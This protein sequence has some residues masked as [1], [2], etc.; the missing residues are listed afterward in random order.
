MGYPDGLI[1]NVAESDLDVLPPGDP[2]DPNAPEPDG[3]F[4]RDENSTL[5]WILS[6]KRYLV[7]GAVLPTWKLWWSLSHGATTSMLSTYPDGGTLG[8][9]DGTLVRGSTPAVYLVSG[10]TRRHIANAGVFRASGFQWSAVRNVDDSTLAYDA[11][12]PDITS[13]EYPQEGL[14]V[15]SSDDAANSVW[16]VHDGVR[17]YVSRSVYLTIANWS[18]LVRYPAVKVAGV[19]A[20]G[21]VTYREGSLLGSPSGSVYLVGSGSLH[22]IRSASEFDAMGLSWSSVR[23]VPWFDVGLEPG[24]AALD[25]N[26]AYPDGA[27]TATS[28]GALYQVMDGRRHLVTGGI[29]DA[30]AASYGFS[31]GEVLRMNAATAALP[32]GTPLGFREGEL[33]KGS[34]STVYL[35]SDGTR[36]GFTSAGIFTGLGYSFSNVRTVPDSYLSLDPLGAYI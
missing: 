13:V 14:L 16:L 28:T 6:G 24:G 19:P 30:V 1:V 15:I 26:A 18:D 9:R 11:S 7:P 5:F 25:P 34:S 8:Y 2:M 36:R 21:V 22:W 29:N 20:A 27:L 12:G 32:E 23:H 4:F 10:G 17:K 33:V 35:I 31:A 3:T